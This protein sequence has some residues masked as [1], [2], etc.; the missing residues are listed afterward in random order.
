[1]NSDCKINYVDNETNNEVHILITS[2]LNGN[3]YITVKL[4][5]RPK[6]KYLLKTFNIEK[7]D[8]PGNL[9]G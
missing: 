6:L 7:F 5:P 3:Y 8:R 9:Y 1:M 4:L 2:F